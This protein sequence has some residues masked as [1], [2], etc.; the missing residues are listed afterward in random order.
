MRFGQAEDVRREVE[1]CFKVEEYDENV[2]WHKENAI[3][4][5]K[6]YIHTDNKEHNMAL[7]HAML[8]SMYVELTSTQRMREC[9]TICWRMPPKIKAEVGEEETKVSLLC[10]VAYK[11][12]KVANG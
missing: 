8:I 5:G 3:T 6:G 7:K 10:R 4:L 9:D 12:K 2:K 11:K 1:T